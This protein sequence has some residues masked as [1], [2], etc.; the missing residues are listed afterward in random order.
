MNQFGSS[1]IVP[2]SSFSSIVLFYLCFQCPE[3]AYYQVVPK[4]APREMI[5]HSFRG[6]P[7]GGPAMGSDP[8]DDRFFD[9]GVFSYLTEH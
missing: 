6:S 2:R 8:S 7:V 3:F 5:E 4:S 1:F 9:Q